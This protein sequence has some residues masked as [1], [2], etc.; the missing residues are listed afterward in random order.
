M[1][2]YLRI[3][4]QL[5]SWAINLNFPF[6]SL[7]ISCIAYILRCGR[8]IYPVKRKTIFISTFLYINQQ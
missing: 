2:S 8:N 4:E 5:K 6:N 3:Y 7:L 1:I